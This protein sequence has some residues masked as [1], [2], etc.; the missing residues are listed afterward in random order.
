MFLGVLLDGFRRVFQVLGDGYGSLPGSSKGPGRNGIDKK[1]ART[2]GRFLMENRDEL[3]QLSVSQDLQD[4]RDL[5][6]ER[7]S[8]SH[9]IT[10]TKGE[11]RGSYG[12][13]FRSWNP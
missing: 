12:L 5:A 4:L 2:I 7:E 8:V 10:A 11:I 3:S 13:P 1:D 9:L 6:R